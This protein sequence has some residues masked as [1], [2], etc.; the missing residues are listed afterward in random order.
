MP[1]P[2]FADMRRIKAPLV[3]S[4]V[5]YVVA[6]VLIIWAGD[7]W[8]DTQARG[9]ARRTAQIAADARASLL[10]SEL[11]KYRLLPVVL[12]EQPEVAYALADHGGNARDR[13]NRKLETIASQLG[14]SI[15]Y[16]LD[17]HGRTIAAS[18]WR[19]P[20]SFVGQDY[21]F[22]PYFRRA[23][24]SGSDEFFGLGTVSRQ[25]GL[26]L[27][28]RVGTSGRSGVVVVKFVFDTVERGWGPSPDIV[29]VTGP[30]GVVLVTNEPSWRFGTTHGLPLGQT[31]QMRQVRQY[32]EAPLA[33]LPLHAIGMD[34]A[35]VGSARYATASV[36]VP[37]AGWT[38]TAL[39][40][41]APIRAAYLAT[42]RLV[43]LAAALVLLLPFGFWLRARSR[44]ELA[45]TVR[46]ML[47]AEVAA[48]TAELEATQTRFRE[49]REALAH[50]NRL[51]S[52]GQITAAVAHEIN[53][54]VAAIRT[55]SENG[56]ALLDVG[57]FATTRANLV[58]ISSLTQHIG[59]ITA[60]L[61]AYARRGTG[62]SRAVS[63]D[64]ALSGTL[65]LAGHMLHHAGIVLEREAPTGISVLA[66]L[67]RLEQVF[68]NLIHNAIEAL[69]DIPG[70]RIRLSLDA[71]VEEARVTIEDNGT[72]IS[73]AVRE[74]L[75]APFATSKPAGLGLGLGI[76]RDIAREFGGTLEV[77]A[78]S[79]GWSTSFVL[80]LR[81][82]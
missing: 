74:T 76:A 64:E 80:T 36:P 37:V 5:L 52:I 11:Q 34:M 20:T 19:L 54:P 2:R 78:P 72:G 23:V 35:V 61:R 32:G 18:N 21:S 62:S 29:Y 63:L 28:R 49:S 77:A 82:A 17:G 75:F 10:I 9:Q 41:F 45:I 55:L 50:A 38:L 44:A 40:P 58:T 8:A 47:E 26:F 56:V 46:G 71:T 48:R 22:R 27:S 70:P 15:V 25:P 12:A 6:L 57:D 51:G 14:H 81:R 3:L 13:L 69:S 4:G 24:A 79:A 16:V 73:A 7:V 53:Q 60:E 68:V 65:L 66:D 31:V 1:W 30:D 33:S 67:V 42:S 43:M 39:E 59:T